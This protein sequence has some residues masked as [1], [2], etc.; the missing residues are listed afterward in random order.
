MLK[1]RV[2]TEVACLAV[3]NNIGF[4]I[5]GVIIPMEAVKQ[6]SNKVPFPL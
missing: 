3:R 4:I 6:I 2:N 1:F 5:I